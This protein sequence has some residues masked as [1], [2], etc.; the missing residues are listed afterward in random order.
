MGIG[1]KL[2]SKPPERFNALDGNSHPIATEWNGF[3]AGW[4]FV[5]ADH[6]V[7]FQTNGLADP[8]FNLPN[9]DGPALAMELQ[10]DDKII[11]GGAFNN[12]NGVARRGLVRLNMDG[13]LDSSF[14]PNI[15]AAEGIT[16]IIT[17]LSRGG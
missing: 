16:P 2:R 4:R 8:M 13:S 9:L 5:Y 1:H 14:V 12:V 3:G 7:R 15:S 11:L 10:A 17:C 6:L